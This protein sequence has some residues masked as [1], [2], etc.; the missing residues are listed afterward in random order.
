MGRILFWVLLGFVV[1][2]AWR[3]WSVKQRLGDGQKSE[4]KKI[5]AEAMVACDICGLNVPQSEALAGNGRWY[6]SDDHR[7]RGPS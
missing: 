5:G 6:C 1:Y 7:R 3:W 2:V 4:R